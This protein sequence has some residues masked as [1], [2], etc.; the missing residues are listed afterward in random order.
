VSNLAQLQQDF[1][2]C[3]Q[4]RTVSPQLHSEIV[5]DQIEA[6]ARLQVYQNNYELTLVDAV[7][8]IFPIVSAFVGDVFVRTALKHFIAEYPPQNACLSD[9]GADFSSFLETYKH[10]E[11]VAYLADLASLEWTVHSLQS[12][13]EAEITALT[14]LAVNPNARFVESDFPLLNL[15]MV[16]SGQMQ[17]EAV[18]VDQGAQT[19]CV[20]LLDHEIKLLGV[21]AAESVVLHECRNGLGVSD[22][23]AIA[24]LRMKNIIS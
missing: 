17:P 18:H 7:A 13:A 14:Q 2:I 22:F 9:Y 15:W 21:T 23:E 20:L 12:V 16:G 11:R 6:S 4:S 24:S 19:V 5:S 1:R 3:V 8:G 10:A